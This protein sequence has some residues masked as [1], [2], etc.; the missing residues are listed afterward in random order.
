MK[1]LEGMPIRLMIVSLILVIIVGVGFW[2]MNFF[3]QFKAEKDFK[4]TVV[5][6]AQTVKTLKS[7]GDFGAFTTVQMRVPAGFSI[8]MDVD[9]DS[10]TGY[11]P[12]EAYGVNMTDFL[13]NITAVRIEGDPKRNETVSLAGGSTY[14][15]MIYYGRL[16]DDEVKEYTFVFE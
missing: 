11:L 6:F 14:N 4:E 15:F 10:V 2:Q 5:T 9:N 12:E 13:V 7:T 3:M 8:M 1:G 16:Q